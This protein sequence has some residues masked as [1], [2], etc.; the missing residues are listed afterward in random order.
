MSRSGVDQ[1]VE[2][3][4][5]DKELAQRVFAERRA[6]AVV[7]RPQR[8]G[9]RS[10]IVGALR[11]DV[12]EAQGE[13]SGFAVDMFTPAGL[14]NLMDVGRSF[15]GGGGAGKIGQAGWSSEG[16]DRRPRRRGRDVSNAGPRPPSPAGRAVRGRPVPRRV[17]EVGR[18]VGLHLRR[19]PARRLRAPDAEVDVDRATTSRRR[20]ASPR[21]RAARR[22]CTTRSTA[23]T[24]RRAGGRGRGSGRSPSTATCCRPTSWRARACPSPAAR[25][26][27]IPLPYPPMVRR[28]PAP[29][30]VTA[31]VIDVHFAGFFQEPGWA[32]PL[33]DT[34]DRR[35]RG[36]LVRQLRAA[37]PR[38]A[39][40]DPPGRVLGRRRAGEPAAA[41]RARARPVGHRARAGGVRVPHVPPR[42]RL[43]P[44]TRRALRAGAPSRAGPRA[45]A[46]GVGGRLPHLRPRRRRHRRGRRARV[47]TTRSRLAEIAASGWRLRAPVD[48]PGAAGGAP[49][50]R[51]ARPPRVAGPPASRRPAVASVSQSMVT[52][53][54]SSGWSC[55]QRR[56]NGH[57]GTT[58]RCSARGPLIAA[59][60]RRPPMPRPPQ[61][62][63]DARCGSAPA[64]RR[65]GGRPARPRAAVAPDD[66][67]ALV[68]RVDDLHVGVGDR[69]SWRASGRRC[70]ATLG[71]EKEEHERTASAPCG[72]RWS[73]SRWADRP[74]SD[75]HS[76]QPGGLTDPVTVRGST[77]AP[78][79]APPG[80]R[81]S[82]VGGR[83]WPRRRSWRRGSRAPARPRSAARSARSRRPSRRRCR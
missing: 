57:H 65:P 28:L 74:G 83:R 19:E 18:A 1:A 42:R 67:S 61:L 60:T 46:L 44:R 55:S 4:R 16:L 26:M 56:A 7:L 50:R 63:G 32:A 69:W 68:G 24:T 5:D 41:L 15:G 72:P 45:G 2:T 54:A 75:Y 39:R 82:R 64:G 23:G 66:E 59:R 47:W 71:V 48:R 25:T 27:S 37:L 77:G 29:P 76:P 6:G 36:H 73:G 43:G 31:S 21:R 35:Y 10:A 22:S 70:P 40:P 34:R 13:V 12:E 3:I 14:N 81:R 11:K 52:A 51:V 80:R 78:R 38:R 58:V 79:A 33:A 20:C 62:L 49:R 17:A 9:V 30:D 53:A 8:R